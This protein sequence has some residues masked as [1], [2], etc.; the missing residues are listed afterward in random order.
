MGALVDFTELF[1]AIFELI[2]STV[3]FLAEAL[4][5]GTLTSLVS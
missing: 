3:F 4:L 5:T 1:I 2:G